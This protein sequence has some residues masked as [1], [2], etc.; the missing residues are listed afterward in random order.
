GLTDIHIMSRNPKARIDHLPTAIFNK[1]DEVVEIV[2]ERR[3]S[4]VLIS[5][6]VFDYPYQSYQTWIKAFFKFWNI[7]EKLDPPMKVFV[8]FGQHDL[9]FQRLDEAVDKTALGALS[10]LGVVHILNNEEPVRVRRDKR[11]YHFYGLSYGQPIPKIKNTMGATNILV[12]HKMIA[13]RKPWGTAKEGKDYES[14]EKLHDKDWF[15]FVLC[16][17]WHNE[18]LWRSKADTYIVNP[19]ALARKTGGTEDYD[20]HPKV[21]LWDTSTNDVEEIPLESAKP[22]EE[23]LT[24][25]HIESAVKHTKKMREFTSRIKTGG[26]SL[27]PGYMLKLVQQLERMKVKKTM[28]RGVERKI[29]ESIDHSQY[30][31]AINQELEN[32]QNA[33]GKGR[34]SKKSKRGS[35]KK[36]KASSRGN[37]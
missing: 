37:G 35:R 28:P 33:R 15:D 13:P 6:D 16:G 32:D 8:V 27:G 30:R 20:R 7:R 26:G 29:L 36:R 14:P 18:F 23:V 12:A 34:P 4:I 10:K 31:E 2:E 3:V 19:G 21:I 5:G 22:S 1:L 24:R 17:D 25:E 9:Y 11:N